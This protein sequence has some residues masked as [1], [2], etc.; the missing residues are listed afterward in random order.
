MTHDQEAFGRWLFVHSSDEQY[1]AD[2][3]L[4]RVLRSLTDPERD[5][6]TVWLPSDIAH[7]DFP[8]CE[9]IADLGVAIYHVP[10]PIAR[11]RD[12]TVA[13]SQRL[14][15]RSLA[16]R[17]AL[18][19]VV[20]TT[21]YGTTSATLP[22]LIALAGT[23]TRVVLHNQEIWQGSER[24]VMSQFARRA[25][26]IIAVSGAT[27]RAMPPS[28]RARSSVVVNT[29]ADPFSN[30]E[31]PPDARR[32]TEGIRMLAAG[33]WTTTKGF[34]VLIAAWSDVNHGEL[35]IVGGPP[36]SGNALDLPGQRRASPNA[37]TIRLLPEAAELSP[38]IL[39]SDVVVMPSTRPESF[40]L[41]ALEAMAHGKPV[42]ASRIGG[43]ADLVDD[44]VGWLVEP[45]DIADLSATL[46]NLDIE[47]IR[48]KGLAARQRFLVDYAPEHY[49]EQWRQAVGL[50]PLD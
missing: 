16:F 37:D 46:A 44:S 19:E 34:D 38:H 1:G 48:T 18:A 4:L 39:T 24:L 7:G 13:G 10:L 20:P 31:I 49:T 42:V 47:T 41:V 32:D 9:Q 12:L 3:I 30:R 22:A 36:P 21:V 33:R 29:T 50:E 11:R 28:L 40:G 6:S 2:R 23:Q 15:R 26:L 8:L 27:L 43:L 5:R 45:G 17:A 35:T 25:N 14:L